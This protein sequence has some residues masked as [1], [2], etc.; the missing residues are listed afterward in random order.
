V[1]VSAI[2]VG[3]NSTRLLVAEAREGGFR[4]LERRTTVTRLGESVDKS[5]EL[6]PEALKRTLSVIADYL[7]ACGEY[8]VEK[9][10]VTGTSAVRDARNRDEFFEG[11]RV[12]TG[13]EPVLLSGEDEA[14][15]TFAGATSDLTG[16]S[17]VLILDI[18]G[19]STELT[20]GRDEPEHLMS[21]DIGSVRLLEK[22]LHSDPPAQEELDALRAEVVATLAPFKDEASVARD[23]RLIGVAGTV[24]Q[25]AAI[26]A[27]LE[28]YDP[29]IVHHMVL[30]HGDVR[31]LVRR[32]GSLSLEQRRRTKGIDPARAD[33]I[34]AGGEILKGVME[35]FDIAEVT[36]SE[37]DI[38]DGLVLRL[39]ASTNA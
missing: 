6:K 28:V 36:V 8:G 15:V 27:G 24:T 26:K 7:A 11:V 4:P 18:G 19:G 12:L 38:L 31:M 29:D 32:L 13:T 34:V 39:L 17:P 33:V 9:M 10:I 1:R 22:H 30:T 35:L 20:Y 14:R 16:T 37:K 25:L 21:Y 5:R 23:T 3:T 2:D